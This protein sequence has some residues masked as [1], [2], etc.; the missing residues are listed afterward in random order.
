MGFERK[1]CARVFLAAVTERLE[2]SPVSGP[3][4]VM[5]AGRELQRR[6]FDAPNL[7]GG[8]AGRRV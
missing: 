7:D 6:F 2:A 1:S 8:Q 5:A 3:G 4:A